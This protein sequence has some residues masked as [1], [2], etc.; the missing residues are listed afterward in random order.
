MR[1]KMCPKTIFVSEVSSYFF[2]SSF[3]YPIC[4]KLSAPL[5]RVSKNDFRLR[6]KLI[7]LH[8]FLLL[9]HMSQIISA[10][11][12]MIQAYAPTSIQSRKLLPSQRHQI[13]PLLLSEAHLLL[14]QELCDRAIATADLMGKA[15]L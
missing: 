14:V 3:S 7:F 8:F 10:I 5:P 12:T 11:A 1:Y 9:S 6:G 15:H 4:P 13:K 2:I